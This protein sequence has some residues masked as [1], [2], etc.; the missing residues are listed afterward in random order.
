MEYIDL[1]KDLLEVVKSANRMLKTIGVI[2]PGIKTAD[3]RKPI[4]E[5]LEQAIEKAENILGK[6]E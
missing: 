3:S 2:T 5:V 4:G 1:A 6:K